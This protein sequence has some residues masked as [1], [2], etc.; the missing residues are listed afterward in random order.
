MLELENKQ[1]FI[2]YTSEYGCIN[3][4]ILQQ[5]NVLNNYDYVETEKKPSEAQERN[6]QVK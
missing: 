1:S 3:L 4:H 2:H 6:A 5:Y